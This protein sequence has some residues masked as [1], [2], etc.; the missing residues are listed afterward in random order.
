MAQEFIIK[1]FEQTNSLKDS[2][3]IAKCYSTI[4]VISTNK[5]SYKDAIKYHNKSLNIFLSIKDTAS[6]AKV[7]NNLGG[8]YGMLYKDSLSLNYMLKAAEINKKYNNNL[9]LASNYINI[10]R[11]YFGLNSIDKAFKYCRIADSITTKKHYY[12]LLPWVLNNYARLYHNKK[13]YKLA[14]QY[15]DSALILSKEQKI[16]SIRQEALIILN[17]IYYDMGDY[18]TS[19][20]YLDKLL[21]LKDTL[22]TKIRDDKIKMMELKFE[23]EKEK[24]L[25]K[26]K[27]NSKIFKMW[28]LIGGLF[29]MVL[30]L[31]FVIRFQLVKIKNSKLEKEALANEKRNLNKE[32]DLKNRELTNKIITLI[33]KNEIINDVIKQLTDS[34]LNFKKNNKTYINNIVSS[35]RMHQKSNIWEEFE[36]IFANIHPDFYK[37]LKDNYPTLTYKELRLCALIKMNMSSKEISNLLHLNTNSIET[38]RSRIRKKMNLNNSDIKLSDFITTL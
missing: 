9:W 27:N 19:H 5:N 14:K 34:E 12:R 11:L 7:Y 20:D 36:T 8:V 31:F 13:Q 3:L 23:F 4:G 29:I 26:F 2:L 10:S 18:K 28:T 6:T 25:Q 24:S 21:Y 15:A 38:A 33:D 30:L 32:L 16:N 35:L 1:A 37:R 22:N 17:K